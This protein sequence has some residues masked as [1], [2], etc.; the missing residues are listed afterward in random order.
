MRVDVK[1]LGSTHP[2]V[3]SDMA[4][5]LQEKLHAAAVPS[6]RKS[7]CASYAPSHSYQAQPG[8]LKQLVQSGWSSRQAS[9]C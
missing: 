2:G 9:P 5:L 4:F 3:V 8:I 6:Q 7:P 1:C